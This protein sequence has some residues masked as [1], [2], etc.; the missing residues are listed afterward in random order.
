MQT[1]SRIFAS[2][3]AYF[4]TDHAGPFAH[5]L[6]PCRKSRFLGAVCLTSDDELAALF[7]A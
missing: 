1:F 3:V 4:C 2:V 5:W 7:Y 6:S